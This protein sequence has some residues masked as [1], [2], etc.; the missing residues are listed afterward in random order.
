MK[1]RVHS[2]RFVRLALTGMIGLGLT[3]VL[4]VFMQ[5]STGLAAPPSPAHASSLHNAAQVLL[6][7]DFSGVSEKFTPPSGWNITEGGTSQQAIGVSRQF[8]T[9]LLWRLTPC[10]P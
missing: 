5:V 2:Q 8:E 7:E 10:R 1:I 4:A 3:L 6:S 9:A